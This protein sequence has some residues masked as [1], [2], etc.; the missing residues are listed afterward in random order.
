MS[1]LE[2]GSFADDVPARTERVRIVTYNVH[3]PLPENAASV[4]S[5]LSA[6]EQLRNADVWALQ[7]VRTSKTRNFAREMAQ[8]LGINYAHAVARPR[9]GGWEG[10]SFLSRFPIKE[11]ERLELPHLDTGERLRI[12]LFATISVGNKA[13]SLCNVH[14]PI[15][16]DHRKRADQLRLILDTFDHNRFP[17]QIVIGDFNTITVSLR[18]LYDTI[19]EKKG[20]GTPFEGSAKTYQRYFF[21]RFKLDWIYLKRLR[22]LEYGIEQKVTASDHRPVWVDVQLPN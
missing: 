8:R 12:G 7:E 2:T 22:V 3:G 10:L 4:Y 9:G 15:R 16:M 14:L 5:V 20:F 19:L 21:L 11:A 13:I 18:R 17:A 1:L 6:D